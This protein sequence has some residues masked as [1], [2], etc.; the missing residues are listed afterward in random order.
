MINM[1]FDHNL[2]NT[3]HFVAAKNTFAYTD[4]TT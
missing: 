1:K 4:T 2:V 3:T